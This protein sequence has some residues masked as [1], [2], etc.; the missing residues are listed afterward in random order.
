MVSE[1]RTGECGKTGRN[2]LERH[3]PRS[4][5]AVNSGSFDPS[6]TAV[7]MPMYVFGGVRR[8]TRWRGSLADY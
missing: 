1:K 6:S 8:R 2:R 3:A 4:R 5:L 7:W